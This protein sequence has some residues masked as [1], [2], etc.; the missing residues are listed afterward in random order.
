MPVCYV[1][2]MPISVFENTFDEPITFFLEPN[3]E[4]HELAPLARIGVRYSFAPD[5][6]DRTF[7]DVGRHGIR[8][9][10]DTADREV[11]IVYPNAFDLLLHDI[12]VKGG[13]CGGLVKDQPI[14]ATDLLPTNGIVTSEEFATLVLRAEG[15]GGSPPGKIE[16]WSALLQSK[17]VEHMG[18]SSVSAETL[19]RN[20][21]QPFDPGFR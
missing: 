4:R 15:D 13:F 21:A 12:C 6:V 9:W 2:V 10:C 8:F 5:Q 7:A 17:F 16:R 14:Y 18:H 3:D 11:E 1:A 20:L 19:V